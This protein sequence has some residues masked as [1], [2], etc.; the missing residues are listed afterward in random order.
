ME[1]GHLLPLGDDLEG[2]WTR[3]DIVRRLAARR[4][5]GLRS[6]VAVAQALGAD[7]DSLPGGVYGRPGDDRA[8]R[9]AA[10]LVPL[11]ARPDGLTVL[12]TQRTDHLANHAGQVS[13]PGGRLEEDDDGPIACALRETEE[14]TGLPPD[15]VDVLGSL[16]DYVT[17]TGFRVVPI[18]ALVH[19]PFTLEPD[20]FEVAEVFEVPL[21]FILDDANHRHV[22]RK[23]KGRSRPYYAIPYG[24]HYIWGAT[25]GMLINL[26]RVLTD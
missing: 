1:Q 2:P 19:P 12:L 17:V 13:F 3:D 16:D 26:Y 21:A 23:I 10:V 4:G 24:D 9:P 15:R 5:R 6:D 20:P 8:M 22:D 14:E 7:M 25:A 11:V 18:V